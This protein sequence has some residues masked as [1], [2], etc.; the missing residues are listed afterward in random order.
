MRVANLLSKFTRGKR[1]LEDFNIS[2]F[3][4]QSDKTMNTNEINKY[5]EDSMLELKAKILATLKEENNSASPIISTQD[6]YNIFKDASEQYGNNEGLKAVT[7]HLK[8]KWQSNPIGYLS[9]VDIDRLRKYANTAMPK[10]VFSKSSSIVESIFSTMLKHSIKNRFDIK[11]L[12]KIASM[13]NTQDEYDYSIKESGLSLN[14]PDMDEIRNYI[15][16]KVNNRIGHTLVTSDNFS[17]LKKIE[18]TVNTLKG[19][20]NFTMDM[21][22]GIA[23]ENW[24]PTKEAKIK[25]ASVQKIVS[26]IVPTFVG[27]TVEDALS[28]TDVAYCVSPKDGKTYI[29]KKS[30]FNKYSLYIKRSNEDA[31]LLD[32]F[33]SIQDL[34][35][36]VKTLP[37]MW[38]A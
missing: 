30:A 9:A 36:N 26:N 11:K 18:N 24:T 33:D 32:N 20:S 6:A 2:V 1:S 17:A 27:V 38:Q 19:N 28:N 31:V 4:K 29:A 5:K 15:A 22:T 3:S 10:G 25:I 34:S 35:Y 14:R 16:F 37:K 13:I 21:L 8:S 23:E 7:F 12:D